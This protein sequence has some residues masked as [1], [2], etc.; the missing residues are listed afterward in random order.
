MFDD[1]VCA[2]QKLMGLKTCEFKVQLKCVWT[3]GSYEKLD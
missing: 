1:Q 2:A 3:D